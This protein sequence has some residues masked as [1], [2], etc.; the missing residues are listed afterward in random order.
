MKGPRWLWPV[1]LI[2][3]T[4]GIG[5]AA[6]F[7]VAGPEE[8]DLMR[9]VA[10]R[11]SRSPDVV[12]ATAQWI[13]WIGDA[14]QRSLIMVAFALWLFFK[15]RP[16]AALVMI[17]TVPL[18]GVTSSILKEIYARPRPDIVPHLDLVTNFSYPSGHSVNAMTVL[19]LGALLMAGKARGMWILLAVAGGLVI[20]LSRIV[21]GV[22]YPSDVVGG[23][24]IGIAFALIGWRVAEGLE[25]IAPAPSEP[26]AL[27]PEQPHSPLPDSDAPRPSAT[28]SGFPPPRA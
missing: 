6:L 5:I 15:S 8:R 13:T 9:E 25:P 26:P 27:S 23:W 19:L 18:A 10:L 1:L 11:K 22:H 17:V 4:L 3:A 2:V 28:V 14:A 16:R 20:G 21:L 24:L 7:G 12:I